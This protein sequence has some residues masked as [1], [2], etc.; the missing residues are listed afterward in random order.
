VNVVTDTSKRRGSPWFVI[1]AVLG[2]AA[3]AVAAAE[4]PVGIPIRQPRIAP[5]VIRVPV[6]EGGGIKFRRLST[7]DGLSQTR[8]SEIVQDDRGFIWFG[9]Q[10]GLDRFDG[11]EFKAFVHDPRHAN[12]LSGADITALFKDRS[13]AL[14]IGCNLFLDRFDPHTETFTHLGSFGGAV[15]HISQGPND[16]LW[17]STESGLYN[18]D[19]KTKSATRFGRN[20][21]DP[22]SLRSD[23]VTWTGYDHEGGF[24]V[25]TNEALEKFD[26]ATG[27]V[28]YRVPVS[29]G[30]SFRQGMAVSFF[31]DR[32]GKFW[33]T[34]Q[35]GDG[36]ALLDREAN[37]LTRYSFYRQDPPAAAGTGVTAILE[38]G[39]GNLWLGSM[40][41]GLLRFDRQRGV[42]IHY[43]NRA[44]DPQSIAEDK[45]IAL[46]KD[47]EGNIWT[48]LHSKGPNVFARKP[49]MFEAFKH[50]VD[51]PNSLSMDFVNAIYED[52]SGS[53]WIGNDAGLNRIDRAT[54]SLTS[55][56]MG[57]GPKPTVITITQGRSGLIWLGT[58]GHGLV[59]F[60]QKT[61]RFRFYR[62]SPSDPRSLSSDAV[63]RLLI[64][65]AGVLWVGTEDGLNRFDAQT[66]SFTVYKQDPDSTDAQVYLS[67]A[68]DTDGTLWLGTH[69]S[70]L[71]RFDPAT[72]QFTVY[73]SEP[74]DTG[75]LPDNSVAAVL[76][77]RT[78]VVWA[79]TESGLARLDRTTGRFTSFDVLDGLAGNAVA[80]ILE[81]RNGMLWMSANQGLS[82]F[83]PAARTFVRYSELDG[84]PGNDLSGWNTCYQSPRGEMFFGGFPGAVAFFPERLHE[85][86]GS[87]AIVL[88]DFKLSGVSVPISPES[89]LTRAITYTEKLRLS[90]SQNLFSVTFAGLDYLNPQTTRYRYRLDGLEQQWN[91]VGSEQRRASY[92]TLPSGTYML[93]VQ[94][95]KARGVWP[96]TGAQL[97]IEVLPPWW[98]SWW[99]RTA[100]GLL[101]MTLVWLF[102]RLR[103]HQVSR[104]LT[105]RVEERLAERTRIAQELHDT[106]LQGLTSASLQLEVADRQIATDAAVKP[107]V[108]RISQLLRQL[109]VESRH[110]VRGLRF[111]YSEEESLERALTQISKD[112][113]APH[114][115]KYQVIVEGTP[116]SLRPLIR[117]EI[118]RI[119]GEALANAFR[120]ARASTVETVLEYGRA[121]FR[122][123][124]R[125]N[126]RGIDPEVLKGGREGH[127]GLS[128]LRERAAQIGAQVK[129]RTAPGAGT[130]IDLIVPATAAFDSSDGRGVISQLKK[131]CWPVDRS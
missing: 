110:T 41:I 27:H 81:D 24:W 32:E 13:G 7:A 84:L 31:E 71:H 86:P 89:L 129:I 2:T 4:A 102:Y 103:V 62:H 74:R 96:D 14:W 108:Q 58:Y 116:R 85:R 80:C 67:M 75:T 100:V 54:G 65:H 26:P 15:I 20:P 114:N 38:D 78:G 98:E 94:A 52:N 119:G 91:E 3:P 48:G 123:L 88:T 19:P 68:E 76:I 126:G 60:D 79:G 111:R 8:V 131:F 66:D 61:G 57:L 112:L 55:W 25:G 34:Y 35:L 17:L 51:N 73:R 6:L 44:G 105:M 59:A 87:P 113:A 77:S 47:R 36:L 9:T 104:R 11:Y 125:D 106:V 107:L 10:Y 99:F 82:R 90:H 115:V 23:V 122:L 118:Y 43:G 120:H 16:T 50:E 30:S 42:F 45:V 95:A 5:E 46:F 93:R 64:D 70:G 29:D 124:V 49:A 28:T 109:T 127:F 12:S 69:H 1:W 39:D 101:I 72:G 18:F 63:Y 83:N 53:L 37:T 97:A 33:I 92:T 121:H 117:D 22:A 130:E 21:N 56:N 128:G 40:G